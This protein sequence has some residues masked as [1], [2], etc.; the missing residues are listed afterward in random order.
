MTTTQ[1]NV[2]RR[3]QDNEE[4]INGLRQSIAYLKQDLPYNFNTYCTNVGSAG[5]FAVRDTDFDGVD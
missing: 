5:S 4:L 3:G 1:N 2:P